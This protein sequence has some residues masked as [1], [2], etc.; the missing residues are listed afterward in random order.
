MAC[1]RNPM[2]NLR[3]TGIIMGFL[4]YTNLSRN[5][6]TYIESN[7]RSPRTFAVDCTSTESFLCFFQDSVS[8][9]LLFFQW[10]F[11]CSYEPIWDASDLCIIE[12]PASIS[13]FTEL[14]IPE[15]LTDPFS[16]LKI[17]AG[18]KLLAP[19]GFDDVI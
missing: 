16:V 14:D 8:T 5:S 10:V 4:P 13:L 18:N 2:Q 19:M 6:Y 1:S 9:F 15:Q 12:L 17:F 7:I 11:F 3:S